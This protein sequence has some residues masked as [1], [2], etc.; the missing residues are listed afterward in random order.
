MQIVIRKNCTRKSE[1]LKVFFFS[2]IKNALHTSTEY[3][4]YLRLG[5]CYK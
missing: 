4:E 1:S 5:N 2:E 3:N